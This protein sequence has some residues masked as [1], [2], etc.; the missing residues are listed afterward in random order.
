MKL[1]ANNKKAFHE[2]FILERIEAGLS[3]AGNEVKSI[4]QG[5]VSIKEAYIEIREG[6]AFVVGMNVTPYEHAGVYR[7]DPVRPRKLLLHK[8]QIVDLY[9]A[10]KQQGVTIVP[11]AVYVSPRGHI[12]LEIGLAKGKKLYDKRETQKERDAKRYLE[13]FTKGN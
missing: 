10:V 7:S 6:E 8:K 5:K 2:Y 11:L 9:E 3:L 1:L 4:R 13:R 12:K